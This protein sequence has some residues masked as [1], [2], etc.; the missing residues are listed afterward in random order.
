V[1]VRCGAGAGMMLGHCWANVEARP[2][3]CPLRL[4]RSV[5]PFG[6]LSLGSILVPIYSGADGGRLQ[7]KGMS[8]GC[9]AG[10]AWPRPGGDCDVRIWC[11]GDAP[12]PSALP[13][14]VPSVGGA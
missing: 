5:V 9:I 13:M 11:W 6:C 12:A 1:L 14:A 3:G 10:A 7:C 2:F 4:S 8:F